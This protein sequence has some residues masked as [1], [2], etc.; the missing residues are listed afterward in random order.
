[1]RRGRF[2]VGPWSSLVGIDEFSE[3]QD[4]GKKRGLGQ[5][6]L[7]GRYFMVGQYAGGVFSHG[8]ELA[9]DSSVCL[10]NK[11]NRMYLDALLSFDY[12]CL[13]SSVDFHFLDFDLNKLEFDGPS[14]RWTFGSP[15]L[16]RGILGT[17]TNTFLMHII[18]F[19][20]QLPTLPNIRL[21]SLLC[22]QIRCKS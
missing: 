13:P 3:L 19:D 22:L 8:A 11:S 4:P 16:T 7:I 17:P 10:M 18:K 14:S 1:M 12:R 15:L 20:I 5:R 6:A 2:G 9:N 21:H